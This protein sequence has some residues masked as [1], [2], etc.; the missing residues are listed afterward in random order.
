MF[1]GEQRR[2]SAIAH[3]AASRQLIEADSHTGI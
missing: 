2:L 1:S 3:V